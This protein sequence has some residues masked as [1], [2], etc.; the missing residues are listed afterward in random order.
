[1]YEYNK[2]DLANYWLINYLYDC[3]ALRWFNLKF[4]SFKIYSK[5]PKKLT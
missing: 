4:L 2:K 3:M 1:M 5:L